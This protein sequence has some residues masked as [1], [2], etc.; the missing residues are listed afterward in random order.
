MADYANDL[1][2]LVRIILRVSSNDLVPAHKGCAL[3]ATEGNDTCPPPAGD[4]SRSRCTPMTWCRIQRLCLGSQGHTIYHV[5][6]AS[7][8]CRIC[9]R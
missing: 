9:R 6:R 1:V 4:Y 3:I 7:K 5:Q 8:G 2:P